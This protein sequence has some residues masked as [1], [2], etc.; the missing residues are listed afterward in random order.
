MV[1]TSFF[2][3]ML[4]IVNRSEVVLRLSKMSNGQHKHL[5]SAG[6]QMVSIQAE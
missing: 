4:G 5:S 3:G 1:L 6:T 2:T